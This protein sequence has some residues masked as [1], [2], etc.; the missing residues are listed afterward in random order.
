VSVTPA[1]QTKLMELA[2]TYLR[3]HSRGGDWRIDAVAVEMLPG[4][5]LLWVELRKNAVAD[6]G[7][8]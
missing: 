3:E 5:K 8:R 1:R 6:W 4:S 7:V 2:P